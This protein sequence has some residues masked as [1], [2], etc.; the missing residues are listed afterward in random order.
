LEKNQKPR[1]QLTCY[2]FPIYPKVDCMLY[3]EKKARRRI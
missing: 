1:N 2:L 3:R